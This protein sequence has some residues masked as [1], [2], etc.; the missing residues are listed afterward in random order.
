MGYLFKAT[1]V[2][3][4]RAVYAL[5]WFDMAPSLS[6]I[7]S[8][9]GLSLVQLGIATAFFYV[10]LAAFQMVGGAIASR[11]GSRKVAFIG[12]LMLGL[13]AVAS[14]LSQNLL[15]LSFARF[16]AG[17][18]SAFFFSPGLAILKDISPPESYPKQVGIYNGVFGLGA[19]AGAF[20]WV[21]VDS[22]IGWRFGLIAGGILML[23][24]ALENLVVLRGGF[25]H[26]AE[27][28]GFTTK[29]FTIIKN[30]YL[31]LLAFGTL[32]AMFEETVGG[33]FLV[34][35]GEKYL[36]ISSTYSGLVGG[37]FLMIGFLGGVVGG[38]FLSNRHQ[39]RPFTYVTLI[40]SGLAFIALPFSTSLPLLVIVVAICGF[41]VQS[42]FSALYVLSMPYIKDQTM[43]PFS[44]SFVNFVGIA[45]GSFSPYAFTILTERIGPAYGWVI[46]GVFGILLI[47]L[48][49]LTA[50]G[51]T[52]L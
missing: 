4:A 27:S 46:L 43:I 19:G 45:F 12:L 18:G 16:V 14:G 29:M 22:G 23:A 11:I 33:Q 47:P 6:Y 48:L 5:S 28:T 17:W 1:S 9:L 13:G 36:N 15:D 26:K 3:F 44:L 42:G 21:F 34:Y 37:L 10:G 32:G 25:E 24:V 20:G 7:S 51:E 50:K 40:V 49:S 30:K 2:N 52:N 39:R 38:Y 35:F 41:A 8:D 31:W